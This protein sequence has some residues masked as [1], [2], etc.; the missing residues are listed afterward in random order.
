MK[1]KFFAGS[2]LACVV[3]FFASC[4]DDPSDNPTITDQTMSQC[5]TFVKDNTSKAQTFNL[6]GFGIQY[7]Y[8]AGTVDISITGLSLP[9]AGNNNGISY[10]KMTFSDLPWTY[11]SRGWKVVEANNVVPS[12]TGM[13]TAPRFTRFMFMLKDAADEN[14][15]YMP[16]VVYEF[17]I[18]SRYEAKGLCMVGTTVS[19]APDG[20]VYSPES[21][22]AKPGSPT[23][24][25]D[26]DYNSSTARLYIY[27]AKFLGT[28]P[29]LSLEFPDIPFV[30]DGNKLLLDC[31]ALTPEYEG[32]PYPSFPITN[33]KATLDYTY[34]LSL[35][36]NCNFR[37]DD[38]KVTFDGTF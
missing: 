21:D 16:G 3:A 7:N 34:G 25:I 28:M 11:D 19:T 30:V 31:A 8:T 9:V 27:G 23:Y 4:N 2:V 17:E 32:T 24:W 6:L 5:V 29:S 20:T 38:Y 12:I 35:E 14:G 13:S 1:R 36:F 10:P 33:L 37:G 18:D 22:P 26:V 15:N